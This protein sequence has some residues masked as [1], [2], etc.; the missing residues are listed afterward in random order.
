M[1]AK[2]QQENKTA[3]IYARYSSHNQRDVSIDQQV[4]ADRAYAESQG[5][6]IIDIYADRALTGTSDNRPEFQ[7]MIL[8]AK[9]GAFGYVIVYSLD[10]FARDRYDSVVYKRQLR[11]SGVRVVSAM[12]NISD[13]PTGVLM[14]SVLEGLA[15][16]Y[17]RE[18]SSKIRR[19]L[20][21]NAE[22]LMV[23]CALPMGYRKG[24]DGK[25][26]IDPAEAAVVQEIFSRVLH[27]DKLID[28]ARDLNARGIKTKRGYAWG[29]SSFNA[30]LSNE[31]YIGTYIYGDVRVDGGM[32]AIVDRS[33]FYA[34]QEAVRIKKN[35]RNAPIRRR[36]GN[37][38][39]LL[40]GKIYCGH[41]KS[42]MIG[43]SGT[44]RRGALYAYYACK[45]QVQERTC[46]KRRISRDKTERAV[47]AALHDYALR[48]DVI[49]WL[50]DKSIEYQA[51]HAEPA[52]L[53]ALKKQLRQTETAITNI[54]SAI[55]Q[56]IFTA[57]TK[58]RL[59]ELEDQ[60]ATLTAQIELKSPT[61]LAQLSRDDIISALTLVRVGDLDDK[62]YQELL[63]D[64]FLRAVYVYDDRLKIVFNYAMEGHESSEI[65]FDIDAIDDDGERFAYDPQ[66]STTRAVG[67]PVLRMVCG[68][69]VLEVPFAGL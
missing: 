6:T 39:Y 28:I 26:E 38:V 12:E 10:R 24:K 68:L 42:A 61:P 2:N 27:G 56:G 62:R 14:E 35:P 15:E 4:K 52:E 8:D 50:A 21:D 45:K 47:A 65:P 66:D 54:M 34:V 9:R 59:L 63:F 60:R 46:D 5:L 18:L 7:R 64:M 49:E 48:D 40:T 13:D 16:Y 37:G 32:P 17:S 55:E 19:G 25:P 33:T 67:E 58:D 23:T 22:K 20:T 44:G 43:K 11:E 30:L 1:P 36:R 53:A 3:V 51:A 31:R 41:C 29:R 57:T 69:F